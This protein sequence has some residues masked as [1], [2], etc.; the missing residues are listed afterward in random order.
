MP[1]LTYA[2]TVCLS[3]FADE[4]SSNNATRPSSSPPAALASPTGGGSFSPAPPTALP[5]VPSQRPLE[6]DRE[7]PA[8]SPANGALQP[9]S[10]GQGGGSFSLAPTSP[11]APLTPVDNTSRAFQPPS[12]RGE[13]P[14][15]SSVPG[16]T[17]PDSPLQGLAPRGT[18]ET[19]PLRSENAP[20][21]GLS[22]SVDLP[23]SNRDPGRTVTPQPPTN[24]LSNSSGDTLTAPAASLDVEAEPEFEGAFPA[25][26][27]PSSLPTSQGSTRF[28]PNSLPLDA[29]ARNEVPHPPAS[30]SP[31]GT[32]HSNNAT[33]RLPNF[34]NQQLSDTR[35]VAPPVSPPADIEKASLSLARGLLENA[36]QQTALRQRNETTLSLL[37]ALTATQEAGQRKL[38]IQRYWRVA[39]INLNLTHALEER[40][41][42]QGVVAAHQEDQT[43]LNAAIQIAKTRVI[44]LQVQLQQAQFDLIEIMGRGTI[45]QAPWPI[46]TPFIGRYRT[47]Y[48]RYTEFRTMP[49]EI[50]RIHHSLPLM[51]ELIEARAEAIAALDQQVLSTTNAYR[52]GQGHLAQVLKALDTLSQQ[53]MSMLASIQDY[54]Q[55][56]SNYA[57]TVAPQGLAPESVVPMLIKTSTP[58]LAR[59]ESTIRRTNFQAPGDAV[60]P[61]QPARSNW[62]SIVPR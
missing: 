56:I 19:T 47:N 62:H 6:T 32:S 5:Q 21:N 54:N 45:E 24:R 52:L 40:E 35:T 41:I 26:P 38:I 9:P 17:L 49:R 13:S 48:E 3:L 10:T 16:S 39:I 15:T 59:R 4:T 2:V 14:V 29:A 36:E 51:L 43:A 27:L 57:L 8:V 42:L 18:S 55:M 33:P 28:A 60:Q 22:Q 50:A 44:D 34:S 11:A 37:E 12:T 7:T 31:P 58:S 30:L 25:T 61:T 53:R 46:D 1:N 20:A 23:L